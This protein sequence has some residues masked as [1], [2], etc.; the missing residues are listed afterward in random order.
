M[1]KN[2]RQ[3]RSEEEEQEKKEKKRRALFNRISKSLQI[4][5]NQIPQEQRIEYN[6]NKEKLIDIDSTV[7]QVSKRWALKLAERRAKTTGTNDA[8]QAEVSADDSILG[9]TSDNSNTLFKECNHGAV[10]TPEQLA[11][12]ANPPP[13]PTAAASNVTETDEDLQWTHHVAS[14]LKIVDDEE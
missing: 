10:S 14:I 13:A 3:V 4:L 1:K 11:F 6:P 9:Q 12:V 8:E 5:D 7:V 2:R